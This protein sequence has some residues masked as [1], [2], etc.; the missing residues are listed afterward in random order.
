MGKVLV[1]PFDMEVDF[2]PNH[3]EIAKT[4]KAAAIEITRTMLAEVAS[5][6]RDKGIPIGR[7]NLCPQTFLI[8]NLMKQEAD[9]LLE[10]K[11]WLSKEITVAT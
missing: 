5:P 8:H 4:L 10:R 11:I 2:Q 7:K 9:T 3:K 1:H 6:N